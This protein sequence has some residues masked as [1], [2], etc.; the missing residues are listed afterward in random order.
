MPNVGLACRFRPDGVWIDAQRSPANND[1]R[2]ATSQH[3]DLLTSPYSYF[4]DQNLNAATT[5]HDILSLKVVSD[6][7]LVSLFGQVT[8]HENGQYKIDITDSHPVKQSI[9][10]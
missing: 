7:L 5:D 10:R 1:T 3:D 9:Q 8:Y 6:I 2:L 4:A